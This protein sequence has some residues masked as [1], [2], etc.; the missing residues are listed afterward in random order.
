MNF[1]QIEIKREYLNKD[2]CLAEA[3]RLL[4]EGLVKDMSKKQLARE[5]YFHAL[6]FY[7]SEKAEWLKSIRAH[8][9]PIDLRNGGD[10]MFRR[11]VYAAAWLIPGHKKTVRAGSYYGYK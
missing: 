4:E 3:G 2:A 8:A 6:A 11:A 9:N 5:I 1:I 10:T 7:L